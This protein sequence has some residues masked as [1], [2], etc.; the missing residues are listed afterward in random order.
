MVTTK[1]TQPLLIDCEQTGHETDAEKT[2][3]M[4]TSRQKNTGIYNDTKIGYKFSV[5]VTSS[6][7][8]EKKKCVNENI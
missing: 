7:I 5:R 3:Y 6:N 8:Y 1:K 2:K 4:F